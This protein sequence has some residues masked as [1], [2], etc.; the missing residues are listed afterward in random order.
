MKKIIS[1]TKNIFLL[2]IIFGLFSLPVIVSLNLSPLVEQDL[3]RSDNTNEYSLNNTNNLGVLGVSDS[4]PIQIDYSARNN[5]FSS[6]RVL[7][8]TSSSRT[9]ILYINKL[10]LGA[11]TVKENIYIIRNKSDTIQSLSMKF[12][13][14]NIQKYD[15][16]MSVSIEGNQNM[17]Y[18]NGKFQEVNNIN[19]DPYQDMI[20]QLEVSSNSKVDLEDIQM[21][22]DFI[23]F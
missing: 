4:G 21:R 19:I 11:T 23:Y 8:K 2:S 5:V 20:I 18:S 12:S 13:S 10:E 17:V 9:S 7:S 6:E 3:G 1:L 15:I 16:Y 14:M 22:L